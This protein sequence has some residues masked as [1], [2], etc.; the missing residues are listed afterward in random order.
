MEY[1]AMLFGGTLDDN[2]AIVV[3]GD[4]P[5]AGYVLSGT[6][7][8]KK[9]GDNS[10][11]IFEIILYNVSPQPSVDMTLDATS[12][13]SFELTFDVLADEDNNIA[14]ITPKTV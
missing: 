10:I 1:M 3:T 13:G 5:S 11:Q 6:F 4:I 9:H 7:R 8:G 14:K 12:I 2:G